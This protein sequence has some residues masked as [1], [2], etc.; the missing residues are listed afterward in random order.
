[1]KLEKL[2]RESAMARNSLIAGMI[3]FA[4]VMRVV[5]H[6]WNLAPIGALALFSGAV[7]RS[8]IVAFV[9]P[10]LALIAGDTILGFH[11]LVPVVYLSFCISTAIGLCL[12]EN[13]TALRSGVAI[14][15]GTIQFFLITNL[16]VWLFLNT[17]PKT[18]PGL[19]SCY[20]AGAPFFWNT[21][22]GDALYS[23][24]FFGALLLA[25]RTHMVPGPK[26]TEA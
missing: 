5:P 12:R 1:M 10:L 14:L 9:F 18:L 8:P 3:L 22:A 25:E 24:L 17:Y 11:I 7:V 16:G 4:A 19:F 20:I 26:V 2:E 21:L 13:R 23:G 15:A 6:P